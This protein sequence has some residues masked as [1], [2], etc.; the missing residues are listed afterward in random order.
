M[1]S[2]I[3]NDVEQVFTRAE[4]DEKTRACAKNRIEFDIGV[5]RI[6]DGKR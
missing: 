6:D 2:T 5:V 4:K 3:N 1:T